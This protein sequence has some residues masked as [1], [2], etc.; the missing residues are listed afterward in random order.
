MPII[1]LEQ[2]QNLHIA[3]SAAYA[4][5]LTLADASYEA[6]A[7][8]VPSNSRS[9]TYAWLGSMPGM[10][11]WVGDRIIKELVGHHYSLENQ[12]FELTISVDRNDFEDDNFGI[13]TPMAANM[14]FEGKSHKSRLVWELLA[15]GE[16]Q[17]GYDGQPFFSTTHPD[18]QGGTQ[19]NLIAG[20]GPAWYV[21]D[22]TRPIKPLIFQLRRDIELV[23][24]TQVTDAN[25]FFTKKFIWG[26][27]GRYNA[28]FGFWQMA[29]KSKATLNEE[30]LA[31]AR[32]LM[33]TYVDSDGKLLAMTPA[34]L[35]VGP[36]LETAAEKLIMNLVLANGESNIN[37]GKYKLIVS[38]YLP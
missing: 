22:T 10:R 16:N 35:V 19:S 33:R 28:G 13:Y 34:T 14:A 37:R 23:A 25:V 24:L 5:G 3:L 12:D 2:I 27:D 7:T 31:A 29:V 9:N 1:N 20:A 11:K 32:A 36:S 17:E 4:D 6:I 21:L 8:I 26:I 38:P 15:D 18:G 30:N